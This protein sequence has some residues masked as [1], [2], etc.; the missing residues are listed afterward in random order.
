M[1]KNEYRHLI[2]VEV[3]SLRKNI[4]LRFYKK[5]I[6]PSNNAVF[7][8]RTMQYCYG[9]HTFHGKIKAELL[10]RKLVRRYGMCI[11]KGCIFGEGLSIPH[12]TAI[13]IGGGVEAG[14]RLTI[15]QGTT[16]GGAH[17]GDA[18]ARRQ[19]TIGDNVT[20]FANSSILGDVTVADNVTIGGHSLVLHDALCVGG[21]YIGSPAKLK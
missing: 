12:P 17:I 21:V 2:D 4:F 6:C 16:I 1:N 7:L 20:L 5:Y 14:R 11:G 9:K 18:V 8:I 15:Y 13:V 19:P 3:Y 10:Q